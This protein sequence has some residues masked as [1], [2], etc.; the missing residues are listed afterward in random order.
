MIIKQGS[1]GANFDEGLTYL[2]GNK[3]AK[4]SHY[5]SCRK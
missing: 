4:V 5:L 3:V 2:L 1:H